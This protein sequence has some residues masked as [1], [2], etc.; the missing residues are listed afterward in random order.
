[1]RG[2][3]GGQTEQEELRRRRNAKKK[4][5]FDAP[6]IFPFQWTESLSM[7]R[8]ILKRLTSVKVRKTCS[9]QALLTLYMCTQS[10][11]HAALKRL[12]ASCLLVHDFVCGSTC[13][14]ATRSIGG[15]EYGPGWV[16]WY[17]WFLWTN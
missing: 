11:I 13:V 8:N 10:I 17:A 5:V 7:M 16:L 15:L 3:K 9:L 1:M 14:G 6:K 2:G 12:V 4:D